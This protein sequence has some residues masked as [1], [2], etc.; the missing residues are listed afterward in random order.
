M[1]LELLQF[2]FLNLKYQSTMSL[3][4]TSHTE[5]Q[6]VTYRIAHAHTSQKYHLGFGKEKVMDA[7][8]TSLLCVVCKM[9]YESDKFIHT[10]TYMHIEVIR[11][12]EPVGVVKCEYFSKCCVQLHA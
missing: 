9:D 6:L 1:W 10:P 4:R 11:V 3:R 2:L 12:L 8:Q 5:S 7:L